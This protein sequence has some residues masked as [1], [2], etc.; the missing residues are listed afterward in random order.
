[1]FKYRPTDDFAKA[2]VEELQATGLFKEA[3][4]TERESEGDLILRG[5]IK[6]THYNQKI[7]SYGLSGFGELFWILGLPAGTVS[8]ELNVVL[9]IED[10]TTKTVLWKNEYKREYD[11]TIWV[12]Y[13]PPN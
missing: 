12:Y 8:N 5:E 4:F 11:G 3:F 1:D 7:L 2:A 9:S 13:A 6:S 10:K